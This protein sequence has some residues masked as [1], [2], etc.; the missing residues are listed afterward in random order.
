VRARV[1]EIEGVPKT[2]SIRGCA[3]WSVLA[4]RTQDAAP[5]RL[6]FAAP[7]QLIAGAVAV[8]SGRRRATG[9]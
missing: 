8:A 6:A 2:G 9:G 5:E 3:S 1:A 4:S 7:A